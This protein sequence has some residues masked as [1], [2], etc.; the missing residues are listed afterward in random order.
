VAQTFAGAPLSAPSSGIVFEGIG[1]GIPGFSPVYNPPDTNGRVGATQYVQWGNATFAVFKK[2]GT[3]LYGPVA[4]N[5]LF[6]SLGG[7]CASHN[8]GDGVVA[9]DI[10]SGRWIISQ[11]VVGGAL[12]FPINA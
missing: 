4:A 11:F 6:Q 7:T 1:T 5:T 2:D 3:L 10:L 8:D 12:T 9:Y